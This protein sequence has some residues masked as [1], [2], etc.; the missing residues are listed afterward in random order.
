ML[1][2]TPASATLIGGVEF[3]D[4]TA[5]FADAVVSY[6]PVII[7]GEPTDANR[8]TSNALGTPDYISG[9][10]CAVQAD[11]S[12]VSLGSG[13]SITLAFIDNKLTG[14]GDAALDLWIFEVGPDVEDTFVEISMNGLDWLDVG[15]VFGATAGIDID[16]F[17]FGPDDLFGFVRLTDDPNAD[18][19]SGASVGADIDAV[20]AITTVL[21]PSQVP[22]PATLGLLGVGLA[23]LGLSSRRRRSAA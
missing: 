20:G 22:E 13:G 17:G 16:A 4:G 21:T 7:G 2:A 3:P 5:S 19:R 1:T 23:W 11:C 15:K 8:G 18:G 14:S 10:A 12:F 9:G 6:D